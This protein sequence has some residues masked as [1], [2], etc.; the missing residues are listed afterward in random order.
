MDVYVKGAPEIIASFCQPQTGRDCSFTLFEIARTFRNL[1]FA[2]LDV[3]I[4]QHH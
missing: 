1:I 3:E 2:F 4:T